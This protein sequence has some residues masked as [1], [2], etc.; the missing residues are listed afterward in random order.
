MK[1]CKPIA[2]FERSSPK[3]YVVDSEALI[4]EI[5]NYAVKSKRFFFLVVKSY[6]QRKY[7]MSIG[8]AFSRISVYNSQM[9]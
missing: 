2:P 1:L 8:T 3:I 4:H 6:I 5:S 7:T 9:K